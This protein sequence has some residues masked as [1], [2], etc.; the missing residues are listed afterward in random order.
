VRACP[1]KNGEIR[2]IVPIATGASLRPSGRAN[3]V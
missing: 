2:K 3:V 1:D